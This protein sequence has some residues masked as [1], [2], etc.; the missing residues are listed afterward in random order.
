MWGHNSVYDPAAPG[1]R[2]YIE[3]SPENQLPAVQ[4]WPVDAQ[5]GS[6]SEQELL[7][8]PGS[9]TR[10][11]PATARKASSQVGTFELSALTPTL[12][13][14]SRCSKHFSTTV[15]WRPEAGAPGGCPALGRVV[16]VQT[17]PPVWPSGEP[18]KPTRW[19]GL[20]LADELAMKW[21]EWAAVKAICSYSL[22]L[23]L[24]EER[25]SIYF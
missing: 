23:L 5:N 18:G 1:K 6:L 2:P 12:W 10:L 9:R 3:E 11:A 22:L 13:E 24:W 20:I 7:R 25:W 21:G 16:S 19:E 15:A 4:R 8:L 17:L 14:L